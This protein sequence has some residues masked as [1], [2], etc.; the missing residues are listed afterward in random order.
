MAENGLGSD[1]GSQEYLATEV[2]NLD[3]EEVCNYINYKN[4]YINY[5]KFLIF[6]LYSYNIQFSYFVYKYNI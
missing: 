6:R 4:I 2:I 5:T 3:I 1:A